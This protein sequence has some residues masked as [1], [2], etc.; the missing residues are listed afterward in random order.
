[1]GLVRKA[2]HLATAVPSESWVDFRCLWGRGSLPVG[3]GGKPGSG[4]GAEKVDYEALGSG[5]YSLFRYQVR[6]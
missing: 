1:M 2:A 4:E 6:K 3:L 5:R